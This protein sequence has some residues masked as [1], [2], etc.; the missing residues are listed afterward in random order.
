MRDPDLLLC[1][2]RAAARLEDAWDR[3]RTLRGPDGGSAGELSSYVGYSQNEPRGRPRVIVGVD[4]AEAERLAALIDSGCALR[5]PAGSA[6]PGAAGDAGGSAEGGANGT[7]AATSNGVYQGASGAGQETA[8]AAEPE[9]CEICGQR[10][11]EDGSSEPGQPALSPEAASGQQPVPAQQP[12][13]AAP[14]VPPGQPVPSPRPSAGP[15]PERAHQPV[16]SQLPAS[17]GRSAAPPPAAFMSAIPAPVS[18]TSVV[19]PQASAVPVFP[20]QPGPAQPTAAPSVPGQ[21]V[22]GTG[23]AG[24]SGHGPARDSTRS[25]DTAPFPAVTPETGGAVQLPAEAAQ[26]GQGGKADAP[27]EPAADPGADE[28]ATVAAIPAELSGWASAALPNQAY[29]GLAS[30]VAACSEPDEQDAGSLPKSA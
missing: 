27:D 16:P 8:H 7:G 24:S 4:A 6:D 10:H 17:A 2:Q 22:P 19:P 28:W 1:A 12:A 18:P 25:G 20:A 14:A 9:A 21:P 26:G 13:A 15:Q 11:A 29:A 3:W 30:W 5:A 23:A